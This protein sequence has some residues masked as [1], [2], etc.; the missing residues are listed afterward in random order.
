MNPAILRPVPEQAGSCPGCKRPLE[1]R[2]VVV[3][4]WRAVVEGTCAGC[5][6]RL[7]QDLPNGHALVYPTTIDLATG[8]V[9]DPAGAVWFSSQLREAWSRP[10][11]DPV[12]LERR[13]EVRG[14]SAVLANCLDPVYGHAL[15]KLLGVQRELERAG[16]AAVIALVPAALASIVPEAV[17]EAW[18]VHAPFSRLRAWLLALEDR[19]GDELNRFETCRLAALPP[20]PHPTTF[21]LEHFVGHI[22]PKAAGSP[23]VLLSL[24]SD[25]RWGRDADQQMANV[26]ELTARLRTA[27]P[28][29][30]VAAV[31]AAEGGDL[32]ASVD[33]RR[34]ACPTEEQELDWIA[35]MRAADLVIG[36]HGSN[37]V[38]PSGL[39]RA[40]VELVPAERYSNY[41]Q[42]TLVTERDPILA[43][44]HRRALYGDAELTDLSG[45]RVA[46]VAIALLTGAHRVESLMTGPAAG[47]GDG[48]VPLVTATPSSPARVVEP[49]ATAGLAHRATEAARAHAAG[50]VH[51]L[52]TWK[53]ERALRYNGPLP[54]VLSDARGVS[55]ELERIDEVVAF[56]RHQGHFEQNELAFV[57]RALVPGGATIDVGANV[58]A[59]TAVLSRAVGP[60]GYVHSFEPSGTARRR[61]L[62]T[63]EL[64]QL[65]N[66]IVDPRAV[67]D[68]VGRAELADYG[69]GFESW[70]TLVPREIP[71][72]TGV[73]TASTVSEVATTTLDRY[74]YEAG[75]EHVALL[76]VDVEGAELRVLRGAAPLLERGAFDV[77]MV[78]VAD[79]TLGPAGATA[80]DVTDLLEAHDLRPHVLEAPGRLVPFRVSGPQLTL[81]NVVALSPSA[82][83]RLA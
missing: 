26:A 77:V 5:G 4:G 56:R 71:F 21:D 59:F 32:P 76:K 10:D 39:A 14:T 24:R 62:R 83:E 78:E 81:A 54:V 48:E 53:R 65:T 58:G 70:A 57:A 27:F 40:V 3:G 6:R 64:N 20:H 35:R 46:D 69:P 75:I 43:L 36:V 23:S 17:S 80:T 38:L 66:V 33:D 42:A 13:G 12:E 41:L 1:V 51:R 37:L 52:R 25:R 16:D 22:E 34:V 68:E 74:C 9:V 31:G 15:L 44:D 61:L 79:T 11:G 67:A 55:F 50:A 73:L 28:P 18:I 29:V 7:V 19:I 82:R 2:R 63:I 30:G 45:A 47:V 72:D 8:D 60:S 49:A